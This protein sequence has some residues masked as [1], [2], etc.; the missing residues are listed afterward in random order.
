MYYQRP[1][2]LS[3]HTCLPEIGSHY[4]YYFNRD[5]DRKKMQEEFKE[6]MRDFSSG[7]MNQDAMKEHALG[8]SWANAAKQYWDIYEQLLS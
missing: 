4:A 1:I 3:L 6:G 7:N 5:F 2:F 8:F